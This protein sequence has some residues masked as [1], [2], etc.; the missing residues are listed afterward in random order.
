M[1]HYI[2]L[3]QLDKITKYK[4]FY[5]RITLGLEIN[6][7]IIKVNNIDNVIYSI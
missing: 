4:Q 2:K 1:I 7:F 6:Y 5:E 3:K